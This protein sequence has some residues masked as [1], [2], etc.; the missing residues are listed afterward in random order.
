MNEQLRNNVLKED[1]KKIIWNYIKLNYLRNNHKNETGM[2]RMCI[3]LNLR[4][5]AKKFKIT[6]L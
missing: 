6:R 4:I 1:A 2:T 3:G 5:L